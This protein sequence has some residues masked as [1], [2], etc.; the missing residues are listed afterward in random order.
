MARSIRID[1]VSDIACPWCAVG[2][3]TLLAAIDRV[4]DSVTV[5]LH[6]QPF[7]LN[8]D[9]PDAGMNRLEYFME[10][11][12]LS[13]ADALSRWDVVRERAAAAGFTLRMDATTR[14]VNTFDAHR[15]L[16]W[17]GLESRQTALKSILLRAYFTD[18]Q[19]VSDHAV[20]ARLAGEAGLDPD[21]A[22]KVLADGSF[23]AEVRAQQRHYL[24]RGVNSVPTIV[25]DDRSAIGGAQPAEVFE[26]ALRRHA[27]A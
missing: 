8:P 3:T 18:G 16:H 22:A 21:M 17:A 23:T 10:K 11:Y 26:Q 7:E 19:D 27:A 24:A 15:L 6:F 4:G 14:A 20:L 13:R 5:D 1:F 9:M 12:G 25:F 2:L